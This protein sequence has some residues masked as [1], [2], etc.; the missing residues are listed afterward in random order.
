MLS[1]TLL[2]LHQ[3]F[4]KGLSARLENWPTLVLG[5][6]FDILLPMLCI[7][8]EYVRNH[9]YSLQVLAEYKQKAD[10]NNLLKRYEEKPLC[11]GRSVEIFLTHPMHQIPRYI[12][13]LH[14]LLAHTPHDHVEREKLDLS[15]LSFIVLPFLFLSFFP[16]FLF[17]SFFLAFFLSFFLS[18]FLTT[19][20][21]LLLS[22]FLS[23]F[24]LNYILFLLLSLLSTFPFVFGFFYFLFL[25]F[26]L[27]FLLSICFCLL[28]LPFL[29]PS[30]PSLLIHFFFFTLCS[31]F[32]IFNLLY[33]CFSNFLLVKH[34][35][36][37]KQQCLL[38][39]LSVWSFISQSI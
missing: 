17:L 5:D 7:Y 20:F 16:L 6:L 29:F 38:F 14:E 32:I 31:I 3:I 22:F 28:L 4:L 10:F 19:F 33:F 34:I 27:L 24:I 23:F 11:E 36:L 12:I 35:Q 37:I 1:E 18:L 39:A 26:F 9:H 13:T 8:Q 30:L 21:I 15:F 2:F 25:F